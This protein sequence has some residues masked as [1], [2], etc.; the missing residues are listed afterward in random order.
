ERRGDARRGGERAAFSVMR[1]ESGG[2][3]GEVVASVAGGALGGLFPR[4]IGLARPGAAYSATG[5]WT[6]TAAYRVP[7][8][9]WRYASIQSAPAGG[10]VG[11]GRSRI[12]IACRERPR[13]QIATMCSV[14]SRSTRSTTTATSSTLVSNGTA[15]FSSIIVNQPVVCSD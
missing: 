10:G 11:R 13:L 4:R 6:R 9:H 15:R 5:W 14:S 2:G 8:L 1:E 12:R 3:G 7:R